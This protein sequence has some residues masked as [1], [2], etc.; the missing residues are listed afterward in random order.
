MEG[1]RAYELGDVFGD[2][3]RGGTVFM[4]Y[5]WRPDYASLD[6]EGH[7]VK[8]Y[9]WHHGYNYDDHPASDHHL[10]HPLDFNDLHDLSDEDWL[11]V[12]RVI[13]MGPSPSPIIGG[14][15]CSICLEDVQLGHT[16]RC[17]HTF[18]AHCL[19]T[20]TYQ[21]NTLNKAPSCPYCRREYE[22]YEFYLTF[23]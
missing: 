14:V 17:K 21:C 2:L 10:L 18:H 3:L 22:F 9:D 1:S 11:R 15:Q 16:L 4:Y 19:N 13:P 12:R 5:V 7:Y 20:W 6:G 8:M 23:Y